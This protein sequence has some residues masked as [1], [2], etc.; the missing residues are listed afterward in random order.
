MMN[1]TGAVPLCERFS[2]PR[3]VLTSVT[4][5]PLLH[6]TDW[7]DPNGSSLKRIPERLGACC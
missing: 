3:H 4:G 5:T 6:D 2:G 7:H 1:L